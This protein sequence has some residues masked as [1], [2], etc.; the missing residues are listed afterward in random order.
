MT[1]SRWLGLAILLCFASAC[2]STAIGPD[3]GK[4]GGGAP[5]SSDGGAGISGNAG[6]T[7][8]AGASGAAGKSGG[9]GSSGGAGKSGT[10]GTGG[11]CICPDIY[12]PVCGVDGQ[13]YPS[14]C[15]AQCDGVSVA[16]EGECGS[17]PHDAGADGP[18]GHCDQ[19]ND[20]VY[21]TDP[22]SCNGACAAASDP[23]PPPPKDQCAPI[24]CPA[25]AYLCGCV[26]H[27]CTNRSIGLSP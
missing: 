9:A 17:A 18:L 23:V 19:D 14:A 2:G 3:A 26:S 5:G 24:A 1:S 7:G 8:S 22:C 21:R 27:Q 25:I 6:K 12:L 15:N 16:H 11:P 13:T 4:G 20:C 10:A